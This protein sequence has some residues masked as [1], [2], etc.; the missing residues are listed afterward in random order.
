ME[1]AIAGDEADAELR[2]IGRNAI[3]TMCNASNSC[4]SNGRSIMNCGTHLKDLVIETGCSFEFWDI[5]G[6]S[7]AP[8]PLD[9]PKAPGR[10]HHV[11]VVVWL[12]RSLFSGPRSL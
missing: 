7:Y 11:V 9:E 4:P 1:C 2:Q 3:R 10:W 5:C 12:P 8:F 6:T